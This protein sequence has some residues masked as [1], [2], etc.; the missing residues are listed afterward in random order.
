MTLPSTKPYLMRA[1]YEWCCDNGFT[2]HL[3]VAVDAR[4]RVPKEYVREGQIVL[5]VSPNATARLR[6]DNEMVEF[7]ASFGGVP[8]RVSFPV[9]C[10]AAVYAREN[11]AGMAFDLDEEEDAAGGEALEAPVV[12]AEERPEPPEPSTPPPSGRPHLQRVK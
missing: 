1:I 12:E 4:C 7:Q 11:G 3:A 5:N 2:P 9:A 8:R 10:V 6:M